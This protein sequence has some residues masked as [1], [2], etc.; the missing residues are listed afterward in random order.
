MKIYLDD[1]RIPLDPSWIVVRNYAEFVAL[2]KS[3]NLNEVEIMSLDHDLGDSA[4]N[5]YHINVVKYGF[6]NYENITEKTGLD[7]VKFLIDYVID[8]NLILPRI[9][10]HS[11]NYVGRENMISYVN[12]YKKSLG[13]TNSF[14]FYNVEPF[15]VYE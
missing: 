5:E 9:Q 6:I 12:N 7:C 11:A 1:V 13:F 10:V 15:Y 4:M 3:V 2:I 14:C 8:N